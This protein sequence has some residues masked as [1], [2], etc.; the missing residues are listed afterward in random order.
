[1]FSKVKFDTH[2]LQDM[3][4]VISMII[5]TGICLFIGEKQIAYT[6][7]GGLLGMVTG[8]KIEQSRSDLQK[9]NK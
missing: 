1:M 6:I 8:Q 3:I 2:T 9:D 7:I 4:I 5:I